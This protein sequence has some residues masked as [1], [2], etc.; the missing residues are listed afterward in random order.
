MRNKPI[1]IFDSGIGGLTVF[2]E[3]KK[4]LPRENIVYF[5]DTARVPYGIKSK[6]TVIKFSIQNADFLAKLS[7]KMLVVA[8]NTS[9]CYSLPMLKRRYKIPV[10]GVIESGTREAAKVTKK[11]KVGVIGTKATI[12]SGIYK[13]KL[14]KINPKINVISISCPLFVPLVEEGWLNDDITKCIARRYLAPL[15]EEDIDVIILGCTHYPLLK[16][17]IY[18]V[19]GKDVTLIDSAMQTARVVKKVLNEKELYNLKEAK[20][21]YRFYVSDEPQLFKKIGSIFL[22]NRITMVKKVEIG[23]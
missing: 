7:V 20:G 8:C 18:E 15:K 23:M 6:D 12:S 13:K 2:R 3:I 16:S 9:S 14:Q 10:V 4:L 11:M 1:G 21:K 22:G 19:L 17:A 5:G